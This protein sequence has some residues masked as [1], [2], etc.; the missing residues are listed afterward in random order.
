MRTF[1]LLSTLCLLAFALRMA[2]SQEKLDQNAAWQRSMGSVIHLNRESPIQKFAKSPQKLAPNYNIQEIET[3]Q[4][5]A[6]DTSLVLY[7]N[8]LPPT[9]SWLIYVSDRWFSPIQ[10]QSFIR[11]LSLISGSILP[12]LIF[13]LSSKLNYSKWVCLAVGLVATL[14]PP[15]I[16]SS[17]IT[18]HIAL[19]T[20]FFNCALFS[21]IRCHQTSGLLWGFTAGIALALS[22][23]TN[24]NTIIPS[25]CLMATTLWTLRNKPN[26]WVAATFLT[27]TFFAAL[28]PWHLQMSRSND[29]FLP[30]SSETFASFWSGTIPEN[31]N[32]DLTQIV[33]KE[34]NPDAVAFLENPHLTE[35]DRARWFARDGLQRAL[36]NQ[37]AWISS[38]LAKACASY[39][40]GFEF[41][42]PTQLEK[43]TRSSFKAGCLAWYLLGLALLAHLGITRI[44]QFSPQAALIFAAHF[45]WLIVVFFLASS[46]DL[47]WRAQ[48]EP[49]LLMLTPA[50]L[51][52]AKP[53]LESPN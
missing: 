33:A 53:R 38:R 40:G 19:A 21:A 11:M 12:A 48:M 42:N 22:T 30:A 50:M 5:I 34:A 20:L 26:G 37:G 6:K 31:T 18:N 45:G 13:S 32:N 36:Q 24:A 3:N 15:L 46:N 49:V 47:S 35:S 10:S 51:G 28:I 1:L 41:W 39:M 17:V 2:I 16:L 52:N 27:V 9:L 4:S 7:A 44:R 14:S 8:Y 25:I 23:L 43:E 29:S